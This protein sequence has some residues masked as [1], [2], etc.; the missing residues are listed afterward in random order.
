MVASTAAAVM[1]ISDYY[2]VPTG[3]QA[4]RGGGRSNIVGKPVSLLLLSRGAP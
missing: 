3:P 4:C 1:E 2:H